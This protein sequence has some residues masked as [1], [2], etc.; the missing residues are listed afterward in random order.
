ML[1]DERFTETGSGDVGYRRPSNSL[2]DGKPVVQG[3]YPS[4]LN[5]PNPRSN[6]QS[7]PTNYDPAL[8]TNYNPGQSNYVQQAPP[9]PQGTSNQE[10][11][12]RLSNGQPTYYGQQPEYNGPPPAPYTYNQP[13]PSYA[14][15]PPPPYG[16]YQGSNQAPS[17]PPSGENTGYGP[18]QPGNAYPPPAY[19]GSYSNYYGSNVGNGN[20]NYDPNEQV[21]PAGFRVQYS[22]Y[23]VTYTP[24]KTLPRY[25][26]TLHAW[27][28]E[29]RGVG[30]SGKDM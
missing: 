19:G 22:A 13:P 7:P 14:Y 30:E 4:T 12:E 5:Q 29:S 28:S 24:P 16:Y 20:K 2:I 3:A 23:P 17:I 25:T 1:K 10:A 11:G 6:V 27:V 21:T 26:T 15:Q 18:Y 9:T 8:V